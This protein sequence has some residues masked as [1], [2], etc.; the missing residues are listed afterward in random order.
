MCT[1]HLGRYLERYEG[2]SDLKIYLK[3]LAG[4]RK[5]P[6]LDDILDNLPSIL[7]GLNLLLNFYMFFFNYIPRPLPKSLLGMFY[8]I[9]LKGF[10]LVTRVG[11]LI[12][13]DVPR[14]LFVSFPL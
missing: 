12:T 7:F 4:D 13:W 14:K 10:K 6:V 5:K 9:Y 3:K 8:T 11:K 1:G 2:D